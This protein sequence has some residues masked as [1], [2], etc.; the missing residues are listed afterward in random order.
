MVFLVCVTS[1]STGTP[2]GRQS[3][4]DIP[5]SPF[6]V[7]VGEVVK[8][9]TGLE[10]PGMRNRIY[11]LITIELDSLHGESAGEQV[12]CFAFGGFSVKGGQPLIGTNAHAPF[13]L[14]R[15]GETIIAE[16]TFVENRGTGKPTEGRW[17]F[18]DYAV[19]QD[20]KP[21]V[22]SSA[23]ARVE[24]PDW[25][26]SRFFDRIR[27]DGVVDLELLEYTVS[28]EQETIRGFAR[29]V[30]DRVNVDSTMIMQRPGWG[31]RK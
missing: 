15:P 1:Q 17:Q 2:G 4:R 27:E 5:G 23:I 19:V 6:W 8:V 29:R 28:A 16:L 26:G 25:E 12:T 20:H 22:D 10:Y 21:G 31:E 3:Q 11:S 24:W 30:A 14:V 13:V 9:E 18:F 7:A